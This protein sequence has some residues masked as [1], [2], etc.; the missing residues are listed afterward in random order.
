MLYIRSLSEIRLSDLA[1]VGGK[2]SSLG[3][4]VNELTALG[5][6]VPGGFAVTADGFRYFLR[7]NDL[8]EKIQQTIDTLDATKLD[9]LEET[10]SLIRDWISQASFPEDLEQE[11]R[12]SY[13]ADE[14]E[15][16]PNYAVAVRS[17]ATAEDLPDASFAGQQESYLNVRGADDLLQKTKKVFA[18]LYT[19]RAIS[20]RAHTGFDY[21]EISI[22]VGVQK[23]V[24]SDRGSSGVMFTLDTESG[25]SRCG[26]N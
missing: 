9:Q 19:N 13:H 17:S 2:N 3:E 5:V 24:R 26:T 7:E 23:M 20:Y 8:T 22:S 11:I 21:Q 1:S 10:G 25:F 18:S 14:E 12:D 6:K 15:Y 4:M 16:G